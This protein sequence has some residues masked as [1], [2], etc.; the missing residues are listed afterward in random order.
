[1]DSFFRPNTS[2]M[3]VRDLRYITSTVSS[4]PTSL[5]ERW[6]LLDLTRIAISDERPRRQPRKMI[7]DLRAMNAESTPTIETSAMHRRRKRKDIGKDRRRAMNA[8]SEIRWWQCSH[9]KEWSQRWT[10]ARTTA[11][12]LSKTT[13]N[14]QWWQEMSTPHYTTINQ[15]GCSASATAVIGNDWCILVPNKAIKLLDK[16]SVWESIMPSSPWPA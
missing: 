1:M 10:L 3:C 7:C 6:N 16:Y 9:L 11:E 8:V 2:I 5:Y 12:T 15:S 4:W 14:K 13:I